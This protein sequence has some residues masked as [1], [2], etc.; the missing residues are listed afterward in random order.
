[1]TENSNDT[2]LPVL[3][4]L[5]FVAMGVIIA[6]IGGLS[7]GSV[8]GGV[9]AALGAI[10]S[11]WGMWVGIQQKTQ[12]TLLFSVLGF[13]TALAVAIVLIGLRVFHWFA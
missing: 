5:G 6:A 1:M 13:L 7:S 4:T 3:I 10:P 9:V 11:C 8:F 2:K 12:G